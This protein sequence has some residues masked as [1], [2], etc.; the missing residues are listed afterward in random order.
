MIT[1]VL[2][3][4]RQ[5]HLSACELL[6]QHDDMFKFTAAVHLATTV[7]QGC[8]TLYTLASASTY[9]DAYNVTAQ[10]SAASFTTGVILWCGITLNKQVCMYNIT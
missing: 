4:L 10:I 8:I 9:Y 5:R 7:A 3:Q 1:C 6:Q 2:E